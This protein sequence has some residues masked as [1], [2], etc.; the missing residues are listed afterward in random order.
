MPTNGE[1][2]YAVRR[3]VLGHSSMVSAGHHLATLAGA[4]ILRNGGNAI[5]AAIAAGAVACGVLPHAC[6]LGGDCFAIGYDANRSGTWALN[7]SGKSPLL[8]ALCAFTGGI[9]EEGVRATT[10]PGIVRGWT[11]L[12][13]KYG[14]RSMRELLSPSIRHAEQG[15]VI[16]E[17]LEKLI[18]DNAEKLKKHP[19]SAEVFFENG[20]ALGKGQILKQPLLAETLTQI[21]NLGAEAFYSGFQALEIC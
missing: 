11:D 10:V 18:L 13:E 17:I 8:A 9:P 14:T 19:Y 5:D 16:D 20:R 2:E 4:E 21:A 6:G 7:A 3:A 15:F 1:Q 12:W